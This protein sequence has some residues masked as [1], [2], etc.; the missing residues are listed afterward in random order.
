MTLAEQELWKHIRKNQLDGFRFRRQHPVAQFILDFYCHEST[1]SIELDGSI[2]D[3]EDQKQ[4]DQERDYEIR[5][6]GIEILRFKNEEVFEN[7]TDVL[8]KIRTQLETRLQSPTKSSLEGE[9][10]GGVKGAN[11]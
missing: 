4:Y 10:L 8:N 5:Q 6:L 7:L 2:H 9:D 3:L 1:L 11:S